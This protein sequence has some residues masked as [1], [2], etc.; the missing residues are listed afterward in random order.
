MPHTTVITQD[1]YDQEI[2]RCL[3][4]EEINQYI[5]TKKMV[6]GG[7]IHRD[8]K[9]VCIDQVKVVPNPK[10]CKPLPK[11]V[12]KP[13]PKTECKSAC[14]TP[15]KECIPIPKKECKTVKKEEER[16]K[17]ERR[18]SFDK[19]EKDEKI[20]KDDKAV[21]D[22]KEIRSAL[23]D[24]EREHIRKAIKY[25]N[26]LND[27]DLP[28]K[29]EEKIQRKL[30][31]ELDIIEKEEEEEEKI[32]KDIKLL[33]YEDRKKEERPSSSFEKVEFKPKPIEKSLENYKYDQPI[34]FEDDKVPPIPYPTSN[35]KEYI[36]EPP[37]SREM[38]RR[39]E[40]ELMMLEKKERVLDKVEKELRLEGVDKKVLQD[41]AIEK[42]KTLKKEVK[43]EKEIDDILRE[44]IEEEKMKKRQLEQKL[45][46]E[47]KRNIFKMPTLPPVQM[48]KIKTLT[49]QDQDIRDID[50]AEEELSG[51][52]QIN[53]QDFKK[54]VEKLD[55]N[56]K[57]KFVDELEKDINKV[58]K[59][60]VVYDEKISKNMREFLERNDKP[61]LDQ[62]MEY[63]NKSNKNNEI[64]KNVAEMLKML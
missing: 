29:K 51:L 17:V 56:D 26:K 1:E 9:G 15:P 14:K 8:L 41:I 31:K 52:L 16:E 53:P 40:K 55:K 62:A 44:E 49:K 11:A 18:P 48:S 5:I 42:E 34:T 10:G 60:Q 64:L 23:K 54:D 58:L 61:K 36:P 35:L 22:M 6:F 28:P 50:V 30:E 21:R 24:D 46:Q 7:I 57:K 32:E 43:V 19:I 25:E 45:E 59:Q 63:I 39:D 38:R 37:K 47:K 12:C 4:F 27:D 3:T 2:N 13:L 33:K 20:E